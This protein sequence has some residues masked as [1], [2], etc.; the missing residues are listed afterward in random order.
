MNRLR[1][2]MLSL[3]LLAPTVHA[4]KIA[5]T[6][7]ADVSCVLKTI[8]NGSPSTLKVT[9]DGKDYTLPP[10]HAV[11][12]HMPVPV[13][14]RGDVEEDK[15]ANTTAFTVERPAHNDGIRG[16]TACI[17]DGFTPEHIPHLWL[18]HSTANWG[19]DRCHKDDT[20]CHIQVPW[21][22]CAV[23]QMFILFTENDRIAFSSV[24][25]SAR[26]A[27]LRWNDKIRGVRKKSLTMPPK[28]WPTNQPTR[29]ISD[30]SINHVINWTQFMNGRP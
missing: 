1:I 26:N 10:G 13:V 12:L 6:K 8:G 15:L 20:H 23:I 4:G 3:L 2:T 28:W 25:I 18:K 16:W 7:R 29:L 17:R 24:I 14:D 22:T 19:D 27:S 30:F 5:T 9:Y 21:T 11:D